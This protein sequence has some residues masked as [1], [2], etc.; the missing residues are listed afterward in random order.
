[1]NRFTSIV[2]NN[3]DINNTNNNDNNNT[4]ITF[5]FICY[6]LFALLCVSI[7]VFYALFVCVLICSYY[8]CKYYYYDTM[9][10][11]NNNNE[12]IYTF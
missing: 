12:T 9:F 5:L 10:N 7:G 8:Q 2:I 4:S 1:M 3:N 6:C 11:D